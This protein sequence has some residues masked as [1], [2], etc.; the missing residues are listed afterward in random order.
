MEQIFTYK[1]QK[2]LRWGYTTGTCAAAASLAAVL[3]LLGKKEAELVCLTTPGGVRLELEIEDIQMG[4]NWVSCAVRKDGGDDPDVTN[5]ML[6][7]SRAEYG[8][9][10]ACGEP[11]EGYIFESAG[12]LIEL[13]AGEGV[14]IVTKPG[15]SCP[16][17]KPAI[18]PVPRSMIFHQAESVCRQ[19]GFQGCLRLSIS[20]PG[21]KEQAERTFNPRLGILGG[22]SILGTSGLV[23][24][25]SEKALLET[26]GLELHQKRL[27]GCDRLI[28]T[29]GNYGTAFLR[30]HLGIELDQAVKCS[31]FIGDT[32][33]LAAQEKLRQVLLVGHGGKLIK[34]A[35]GVMNTHSSAADGRMEV[36]G[37]WGGALG[38]SSDQIRRI[39][40]A[41]TVDQALFVLEEKK[42]LLEAV[43]VQVMRQV[44][45]HLKKRAGKGLWAECII[46]TNE[47]GILGMTSGAEALL[48]EFE[49]GR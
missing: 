2:K 20:V 16:V 25:M 12:V 10:R 41:V 49:T 46:F 48:K 5:G 36:L 39:L 4:D 7:Y 37:A 32:L 27:A 8:K 47:R 35:A 13:T 3:M 1:N 43:M 29:P 11:E 42:G 40:E 38:A 28:L 18:N 30:D 14:G 19:Y 22:I 17:G 26:I 24:P 21:G 15:L 44:E 34:L 6:V 31:N 33:D 9:D 45:F 23:E